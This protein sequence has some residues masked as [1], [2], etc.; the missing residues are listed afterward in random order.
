MSAA[1]NR[2]FLNKFSAILMQVASLSD[3][4]KE[5][6]VTRL[7][8]LADIC[9]HDVDWVIDHCP[10]MMKLIE[11]KSVETRKAF[12]GTILALF[13]YTAG[14]K[15][16]KPKTYQCWLTHFK[17][18]R[19]IAQAKYDNIQPSKRQLEAYVAWGDIISA[20]D[21]LDRDSDTYLWIAMYTM[22]PPARADFNKLRI[23]KREPSSTEVEEHPNYLLCKD[24]TMRLV[25]N[26]FKTRGKAIPIYDNELPADLQA[27]IKK[28]LASKPRKY[29]LV[30]PRT[31]QPYEDP[32]L[33]AKQFRAML[34][35]I[36]NK[37]V[38]INTLRHSFVMSLDLNTIKPA[39]KDA[40]AAQMMHSPDTMTRYRFELPKKLTGSGSGRQ[41]RACV[42][43]AALPPSPAQ[44]Q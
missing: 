8:V 39:E 24:A 20:R 3:K 6:Y 7:R 23:F 32:H 19:E 41:R 11:H 2:P 28:S 21:K 5:V 12:A 29:L 4:S 13:K 27:I 37:P 9:G 30:S 18:V 26:S 10:R 34:H 44:P 22:I 43:R 15:D 36:F 14:L 38:S 25:L 31:G 35:R 1:K 16:K 17:A 42:G 33:F 40:I